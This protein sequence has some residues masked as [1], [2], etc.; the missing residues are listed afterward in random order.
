M[1][2]VS[3]ETTGE[4]GNSQTTVLVT[5]P[6]LN[7]VE[8]FSTVSF[9]NDPDTELAAIFDDNGRRVCSVRVGDSSTT[10]S[11]S[12]TGAN[13]AISTQQI[14]RIARKFN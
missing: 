6:S 14:R 3:W 8:G 11:L 2:T 12:I 10:F 4:Q 7:V 1:I 5:N 9:P 13:T